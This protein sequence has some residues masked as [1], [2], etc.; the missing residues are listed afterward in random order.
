MPLPQERALST[1][2]RQ[3]KALSER[4]GAAQRESDAVTGLTAALVEDPINRV[5]RDEYLSIAHTLHV[6]RLVFQTKNQN[7]NRT[8]FGGDI[9]NA[10]DRA[11]GSCATR[12]LK[13]R[14]C[15]CISSERI[16]F[17]QPVFVVDLV[18]LQTR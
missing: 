14:E 6:L 17:A 4:W 1:W 12:F 3:R 13:T 15:V 7:M 16:H 9:L 8:I 11:A 5:G 10:M 18:E 2:W